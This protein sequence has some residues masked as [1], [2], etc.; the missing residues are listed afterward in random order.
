MKVCTTIFGR[1]II[2]RGIQT[3]VNNSKQ[4]LHRT[5]DLVTI[6]RWDHEDWYEFG[7]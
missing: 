7:A 1:P 4:S 6:V 3:I 2:K 5:Y